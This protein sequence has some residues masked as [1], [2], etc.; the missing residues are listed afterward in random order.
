MKSPKFSARG[1]ASPLRLLH[2]ALVILVRRGSAAGPDEDKS[3][4]GDV[5]DELVP[6]VDENPGTRG[7]KLSVLHIIFFPRGFLTADPQECPC[8]SRSFPS[9]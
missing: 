8:S 1:T 5:E 2:G 9:D 7:T 3:C 4:D 6:E